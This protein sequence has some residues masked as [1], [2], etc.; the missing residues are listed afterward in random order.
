MVPVDAA[1][2]T[3]VT[4]ALVSILS[5]SELRP[6]PVA[7]L[8]TCAPD[9]AEGEVEAGIPPVTSMQFRVEHTGPGGISALTLAGPVAPSSQPQAVP[10]IHEGLRLAKS[11]R[12][13]T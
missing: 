8:Q 4:L 5:S 10:L 1:V 13:I 2:L 9:L 7:G 3:A 12:V 11:Q 6:V